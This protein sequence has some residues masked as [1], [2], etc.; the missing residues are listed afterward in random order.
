MSEYRIKPGQDVKDPSVEAF[1]R[2]EP[3]PIKDVLINPEHPAYDGIKQ[4]LEDLE[5][6]KVALS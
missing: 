6:G 3:V 4:L 2:G 1:E 5:S